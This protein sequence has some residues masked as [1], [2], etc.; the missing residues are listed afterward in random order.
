MEEI[1]AAGYDPLEYISFYSLRSY[2]RINSD[3]ARLRKMTEASGVSYYQAEAAMARIF[4]GEFATVDELQKN[5][6][7]TFTLSPG[8]DPSYFPARISFR[9]RTAQHRTLSRIPP[10]TTSLITISHR[11]SRDECTN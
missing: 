2:D 11:G 5:Q 3:P 7:V 9:R 1:A 4:L 6:T 10:L 8:T